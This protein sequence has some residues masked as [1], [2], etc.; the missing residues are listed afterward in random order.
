[1]ESQSVGKNRLYLLLSWLHS[2]IVER[3]YVIIQLDGGKSYE[4]NETDATCS[5]KYLGSSV[6]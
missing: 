4:F 2:V 5:F 6:W 3:F 1:M